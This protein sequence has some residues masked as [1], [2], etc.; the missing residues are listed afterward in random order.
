MGNQEL[1]CH[2][3]GNYLRFP[4]KKHK[5]G[6]L[7]I[8]CDYCGHQHCRFVVNGVVTGDRWDKR[9]EKANKIHGVCANSSIWDEQRR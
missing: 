1:Y 6:N 9:Y 3:C 8:V 5:N 4:I 2:D 7:I